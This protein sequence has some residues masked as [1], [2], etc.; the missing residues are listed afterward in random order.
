MCSY[1]EVC[2][3]KVLVPVDNLAVT[4]LENNGIFGPMDAAVEARFGPD[5]FG[6]TLFAT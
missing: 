5:P 6:C 2:G 3:I 4:H 1:L